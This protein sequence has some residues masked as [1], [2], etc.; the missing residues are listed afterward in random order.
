MLNDS[1]ILHAI[2]IETMC[3]SHCDCLGIHCEIE[4]DE[5]GSHPC[6]NNATCTDLLAGYNCTCPDG[7]IG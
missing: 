5:C 4:I 6:Q 1:N 2:N 7:F 3:F